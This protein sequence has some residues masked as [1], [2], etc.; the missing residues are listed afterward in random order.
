MPLCFLLFVL[1][2]SNL[3]V[4]FVLRIQLP[5]DVLE[6]AE[7]S[8]QLVQRPP[9]ADL[10]RLLRVAVAVAPV[11]H[12]VPRVASASAPAV[13]A[14]CVGRRLPVAEVARVPAPSDPSC[15]SRLLDRLADHHAVLLELL[16][17]DRVE[18]G[19][20]AAVEGEDEHCEDFRCLQGD[21][22]RSPGRCEGKEGD[23][24]PA[25]EVSEY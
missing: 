2:F 24:K 14:V 4:P 10:V 11:V 23:G 1:N 12:V 21:Q 19:V 8:L 15:H 17:E 9:R 20:A 6:A 25:D 13:D 22:A 16:G 18:E 7:E 5:V 3:I